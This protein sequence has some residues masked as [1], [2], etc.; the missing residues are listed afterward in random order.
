[1]A[2]AADLKFILSGGAANTDPAA[3]LGGAISTAGGG[4]VK[5]QS[6]TA[7]T[8]GGVTYDDAC[9]NSVG[10]GTVTFT[11]SG[12]T[13][14]WTPPGGTIGPPVN[15]TPSGTY[16]VYGSDGNAQI[17]VTSVTGSFGGDTSQNPVVANET[18]KL[19]DDVARME[20][21][22][23]DT[24]YRC[25]YVKNTNGADSMVDVKLWRSADTNG[26]DVL[27]MGLDPAGKN[28]TAT[29]I[30]DE[31]TAPAGVVFSEPTDI[32]SALDIGTLAAGDY[33]AVWLRRTVPGG[34]TVTTTADAS[35][36]KVSF[37]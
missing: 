6:L 34:T 31:D 33:Y 15:I 11:S 13:L 27:A 37:I 23:G 32:G 14:Q 22:S 18:N 30:A 4:V 3:A 25:M 28:G 16:T 5:S 2:N 8:I 36:L 12:T 35:A 9:G 10:T 7:S 24:E 20:S 21:V 26:A 29:T 1:M 17:K 19:F